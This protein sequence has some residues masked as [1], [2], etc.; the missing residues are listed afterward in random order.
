MFVCISQTYLHNTNNI[1]ERI[2]SCIG[3]R[4]EFENKYACSCTIL[5]YCIMSYVMNCVI[6][7]I[8][9]LH[10]SVEAIFFN[11]NNTICRVMR[12]QYIFTR[13]VYIHIYN[14]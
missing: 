9:N 11:N 6:R 10:T 8:T 5:R 12:K 1:P 14:A 3:I 4:S 13:N 7:E 2:E